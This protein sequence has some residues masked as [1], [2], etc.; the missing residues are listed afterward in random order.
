MK[1]IIL[2]A[3]LILLLITQFTSAQSVSI[4]SGIQDSLSELSSSIWKQKTD[5]ARL[6]ANA[7]FFNK[8]QSILQSKS[9]S[10]LPFDSI[11]GIT[12]ITSDDGLLRIF[13]WNVPLTSGINK[14]FGF[15]QHFQ[16]SCVVIPLLS[17]DNEPSD[18]SSKQLTPKMWYGSIYYQLIQVEINKKIA[19]TILGWDGYTTGSNRKLID[20]IQFDNS[21]NVLFGMPV[22]KTDQGIKSRIVFEYA[23]KAN[24]LL[25][26]DY[27]AI[28]IEKRKRIKKEAKWLIVLDR[29]VPMDP[30]MKGM[31]KYYVP[32]GDTYD[33]YIFN[34][35]YWVFVEDI[36]V[37]NKEKSIK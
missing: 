20:I 13:T 36:E 16:D 31:Q 4:N 11:N 8:F 6:R 21:G 2:N 19:F 28:R 5:S 10:D 32:S 35:N 24:M 17:N 26:Y 33:G 29:L 7:A 37:A 30:S 12:R 23:E 18:F 9:Y 1:I 3:I 22:F 15:I 34:D 25:R 14:Y 27:Q